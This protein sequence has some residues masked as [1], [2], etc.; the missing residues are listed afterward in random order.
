MAISTF[1]FLNRYELKSILG[2]GGMGVV[3][4]AYDVQLRRD[5]AVKVRSLST[6]GLFIFFSVHQVHLYF[7]GGALGQRYICPGRSP[8][9]GG[10]G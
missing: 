6:L 9:P 5:V 4:H 8:A 1:L 3:Y 10:R 2:E 7:F